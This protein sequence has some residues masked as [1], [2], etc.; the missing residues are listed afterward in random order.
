MDNFYFVVISSLTADF[1]PF[2]AIL[3]LHRRNTVYNFTA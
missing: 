2:I 3:W 1:T